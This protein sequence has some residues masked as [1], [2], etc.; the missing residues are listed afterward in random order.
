MWSKQKGYKIVNIFD[1][2]F[3]EHREKVNQFI[4]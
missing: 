3:I 1:Y 2:I 4:K